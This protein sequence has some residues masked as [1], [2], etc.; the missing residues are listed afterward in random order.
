M[1]VACG[2]S[3]GASVSTNDVDENEETVWLL[4]KETK[5]TLSE[6]G[7]DLK[8]SG[9]KV[10]EYNSLG[11]E[12]KMTEYNS[13][14]IQIYAEENEYV[15]ENAPKTKVKYNDKGE[16]ESRMEISF[17]SLPNP[18]KV[19]AVQYNA[20]GEETISLELNLNNKSVPVSGV[21]HAYLLGTEIE[22]KVEFEYSGSNLKTGSLYMEADSGNRPVMEIECDNNGNITNMKSYNF[23]FGT[24]N[25]E[26]EYK[27]DSNDNKIEERKY[28]SS[29]EVTLIKKHEYDE[30]GY[31]I[32]TEETDTTGELIDWIEYEYDENGNKIKET[33]LKPN[34]EIIYVIESE[35][36]EI[37]LDLDGR[38][39]NIF[40][41]G[42]VSILGI[43]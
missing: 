2:H 14:D 6:N 27:Y 20:D 28:D 16:V 30:N 15:N 32:K 13:S 24:I 40:D 43:F 7:V 26:M 3:T 18:S 31:L 4:D 23:L 19:E 39:R 25:Y 41:D 36:S 8:I 5:Y 11:N 17:D 10:Y 22:I 9:Y 33:A 21:E 1:L 37:T 38:S 29:G 34:E 12:T 42:N 35:Y